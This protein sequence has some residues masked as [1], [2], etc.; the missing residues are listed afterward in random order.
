MGR[1][2]SS[3]IARPAAERVIATSVVATVLRGSDQWK[4]RLG[5]SRMIRADSPSTRFLISKEMKRC[6]SNKA[7]AL[8]DS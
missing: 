7:V 1:A 3:S 4:N 5:L 6:L 8:A 2:V